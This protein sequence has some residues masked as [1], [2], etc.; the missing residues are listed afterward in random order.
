MAS[1][2]LPAYMHKPRRGCIV[3]P[4]IPRPIEGPA[5]KRREPA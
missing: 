4:D 3:P 2:L 5:M 1:V